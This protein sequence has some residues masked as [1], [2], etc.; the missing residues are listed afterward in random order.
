MPETNLFLAILGAAVSINLVA[1]ITLL[2][3]LPLLLAVSAVLHVPSPISASPLMSQPQQSQ[4]PT[5]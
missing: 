2:S 5:P 3:H 4:A 1:V